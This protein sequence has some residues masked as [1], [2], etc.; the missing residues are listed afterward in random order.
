VSSGDGSFQA[1]G[2]EIVAEDRDKVV[3]GAVYSV[4]PINTNGT[5]RWQISDHFAPVKLGE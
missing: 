1:Y 3:P 4:K 5:Y 2:L